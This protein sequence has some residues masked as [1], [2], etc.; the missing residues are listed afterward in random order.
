MH[1]VYDKFDITFIIDCTGSMSSYFAEVK[2]VI[3]ELF[4]KYG[5]MSKN[6]KFCI[7]GYTDHPPDMGEFFTTKFPKSGNIKDSE[8]KDV[9]KFLDN[10]ETSGGGDAG[11][12]AMLDGMDVALNIKYRSNANKYFFII[13]D[14]QPHGKTFGNAGGIWAEEGCPCGLDY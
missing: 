10:L 12:E 2:K 5:E 3:D 8:V 14:E 4:K 6:L 1:K 7:I 13:G 9:K 11:G